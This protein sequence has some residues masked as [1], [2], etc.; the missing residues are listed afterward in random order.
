M[1]DEQVFRGKW[2]MFRNKVEEWWPELTEEELNAVEGHWEQLIVLLIDRYGYT[3]ER[4]EEELEHRWENSE[5][6]SP[7]QVPSL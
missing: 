1:I 2:E 3:R 5:V 4:A 6:E 7:E